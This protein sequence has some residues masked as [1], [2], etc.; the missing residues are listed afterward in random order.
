MLFGP[1]WGALDEVTETSGRGGPGFINR[2]LGRLTAGVTKMA[3]IH[4]EALEY[5]RRLIGAGAAR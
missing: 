5:G 1:N 2:P 4:S 3:L